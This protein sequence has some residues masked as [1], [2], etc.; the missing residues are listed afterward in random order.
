MSELIGEGYHD[1]PDYPVAFVWEEISIVA[2]RKN[3]ALASEAVIL[4]SAINTAVAAFGKDGGRKAN[5]IF[6]KLVRRLVGDTAP[7]STAAPDLPSRK[8]T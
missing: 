6:Q 8:Q 5:G 4:H 2:E 3:R 1:A 7:A